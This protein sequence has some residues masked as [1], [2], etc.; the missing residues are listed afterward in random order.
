[1][2]EAREFVSKEGEIFARSGGKG[3][4]ENLYSG[5][6]RQERDGNIMKLLV[7]IEGKSTRRGQKGRDENFLPP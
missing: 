1:M 7:E 2:L 5:R 3:I 4:C 6:N